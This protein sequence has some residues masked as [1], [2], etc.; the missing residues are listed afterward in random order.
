M[1]RVYSERG[2]IH[3]TLYSDVVNAF[4]Y[5]SKLLRVF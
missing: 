2:G 4:E 3:Y 1:S 5:I